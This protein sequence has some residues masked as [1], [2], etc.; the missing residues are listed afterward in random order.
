[1]HAKGAR[2]EGG[3][4]VVSSEVLFVFFCVWLLLFFSFS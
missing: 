2:P 1:M 4:V 3:F